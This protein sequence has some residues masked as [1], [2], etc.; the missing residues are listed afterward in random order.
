MATTLTDMPL[1]IFH[2]IID[3]LPKY[4]LVN[5]HAVTPRPWHL[6][7]FRLVSRTIETKSRVRFAQEFFTSI[8]VAV[9]L[10]LSERVQHISKDAILRNGVRNMKIRIDFPRELAIDDS[11]SKLGHDQNYR[12]KLEDYLIK[13]SFKSDF[14]TT[15]HHVKSLKVSSKLH[16]ATSHGGD[17]M[18]RD[19]NRVVWRRMAREVLKTVLMVGAIRL[20]NIQIGDNRSWGTEVHPGLLRDLPEISAN[21]SELTSLRLINFVDGE[22]HLDSMLPF[23]TLYNPQDLFKFLIQAPKL[24]ELEYLGLRSNCV[25]NLVVDC[26]LLKTPTLTPTVTNLTLSHWTCEGDLP[27]LGD[28][29]KVLRIAS[30]HLTSIEWRPVFSRLRESLNLEKFTAVHLS[31]GRFFLDFDLINHARPLIEPIM[32]ESHRW[33]DVWGWLASPTTAEDDVWLWVDHNR[34]GCEISL[35]AKD[36]DDMNEW[37]LRL[38]QQYRLK[39]RRH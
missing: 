29:L 26:R 27:H 7:E 21:L 9:P 13:C 14:L 6:R 12:K 11:D 4:R 8:V 35:D 18:S 30:I 25:S 32:I 17:L 24:R 28:S 22:H 36:G 34:E 23:E 2:H 20:E 33:H 16:S 5:E 39:E 19:D 31:E 1:D 37:L 38:E 3:E 15:I 10:Q